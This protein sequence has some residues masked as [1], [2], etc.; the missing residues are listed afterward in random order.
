MSNFDRP[1]GSQQAV[2]K[3]PLEAFMDE[4]AT[5]CR[6]DLSRALKNADHDPVHHSIEVVA[7]ILEDDKSRLAAQLQAGRP[8]P[9]SRSLQHLLPGHAAASEGD[10]VEHVV[11]NQALAG[12]ALT[13]EYFRR[14]S[15]DDVQGPCGCPGGGHELPQSTAGQRGQGRG[16]QHHGAACCKGRRHL[17]NSLHQREVPG[18]DAS[19]NAE[20]FGLRPRYE[21][22][23]IALWESQRLWLHLLGR[24]LCIIVEGVCAHAE[25]S[26]TFCKRLSAISAF[27]DA[28]GFQ[29]L[30]RPK[31][32]RYLLQDFGPRLRRSRCPVS[33]IKASPRRSNRPIYVAS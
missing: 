27:Y 32:C 2:D 3:L 10:F 5:C 26:L 13:W 20:R 24:H 1:H 23:G 9:G 15:R 33:V 7:G 21:I 19:D 17:E 8:Q 16:L 22:R 11:V 25:I 18:S 6:A 29:H 12:T 30:R 14:P 31:C 28:E 4:D